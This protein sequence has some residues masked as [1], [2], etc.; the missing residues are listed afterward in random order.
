[1]KSFLKVFGVT[2][3]FIALSLFGGNWFLLINFIKS[4]IQNI[5]QLLGFFMAFLM[6]L[7]YSF[8][9]GYSGYENITTKKLLSSRIKWI[10]I[11]LGITIGMFL[12]VYTKTIG[13]K[14]ATQ[15]F[16][17]FSVLDFFI[18][19]RRSNNPTNESV[20]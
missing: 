13:G 12:F 5:W 9:L 2:K 7:F 19:T 3:I 18:L 14:V 8:Y 4:G 20:S 17:L 1:M 15:L 11:L 16:T 10:G 6:L